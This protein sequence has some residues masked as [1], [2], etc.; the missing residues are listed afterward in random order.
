[1]ASGA[2]SIN[3]KELKKVTKKFN[4][5]IENINKSKRLR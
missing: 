1:M 2:G 3:N 4:Q 5:L